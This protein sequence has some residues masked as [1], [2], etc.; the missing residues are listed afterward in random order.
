MPEN[1]APELEG[2]LDEAVRRLDQ[3]TDNLAG[4]LLMLDASQAEVHRLAERY[5]A[6]AAGVEAAYP[7]LAAPCRR[8]AE[9]HRG[10]EAALAR[11]NASAGELA[12]TSGHL[13][14]VVLDAR[15]EGYGFSRP[16][17]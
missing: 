2:R 9:L 4:S 15:K 7:S 13:A 11:V 8:L 10:L 17:I 16:A 12:A 3:A 6:F 1:S 5:D 14:D